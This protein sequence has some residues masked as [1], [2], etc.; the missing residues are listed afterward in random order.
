[1]SDKESKGLP[2]DPRC[3]VTQMVYHPDGEKGV[4]GTQWETSNVKLTID[5]KEVAI[6]LANVF[7]RE[8]RVEV[9]VYTERSRKRSELV[10][11]LATRH[12][13]GV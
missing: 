5:G 2:P 13:C 9:T 6:E 8:P 3:L 11:E 12:T 7:V 1:M 10:R 4:I